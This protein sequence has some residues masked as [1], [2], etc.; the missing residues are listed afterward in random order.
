MRGSMVLAV[1][2][3]TTA[4]KIG[5]FDGE[6]RC[7]AEAQAAY[8]VRIQGGMADIQPEIWW[9]TLK[10]LCRGFGDT[11][12]KVEVVSFSVTTPGLTPMD[13]EG[14]PLG[15]A[16]LFF[17]QRSRE[18][19]AEIRRIVG[20]EIFLEQGLNLPVSGGSSLASILW[21]KKHQPEIWAKTAKFGHTNTYLVKKMTGEWVIDPS[22]ISISGLYN[23]RANDLSYLQPVLDAAGIPGEKLPTLRHSHE[24][25]GRVSR[26]AA[27]ELGIKPGTKVLC[28]GN[29][30]VLAAYS[31]G[32][33]RPGQMLNICGTCEILS[34]CLDEPRGSPHYNIRCHVVPDTWITLFVLNTGGKSYEWF[35]NNFCREMDSREFYTQYIPRV[36][37]DFELKPDKDSI[38]R[39]MPVYTPF[40]QGSR[41]SLEPCYATFD[42]LDLSV[43]REDMFLALLKGNFT[44]LKSHLDLVGQSMHLD[45]NLITTGRG[46]SIGELQKARSRWLGNYDYTYA[47]ESSLKG[48]AMLALLNEER[49]DG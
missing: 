47:E 37:S 25:A 24:C 15:P 23:S 31:A 27:D 17:D 20:E 11:L 3:G 34:V 14:N 41:Y 19:A 5:L 8:E 26:T 1:D 42:R 49:A 44:Y 22:T 48:A 43:T 12:Q 46:A 40:L 33:T 4:M 36:M 10:S 38:E 7:V 21:I 2:A 35:H 13:K 29:D 6:M 16:I 18:E 30:A 32:L 45:K 9:Q 28:G 39:Q